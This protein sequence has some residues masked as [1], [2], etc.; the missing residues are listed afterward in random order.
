LRRTRE[1][2]VLWRSAAASRLLILANGTST[3][4]EAIE[5][6]ALRHL[7]G[8][9]CPPTDLESVGSKLRINAFEAADIPGSGEL[10]RDGDGFR[11]LYS[12]YLSVERRRFTIAHELAHALLEQTGSRAPRRGKELERLCD[13][14]AAELLMPKSVFL[15]MARG[16]VSTERIIDIARQFR[17]SV[18]ATGLRYAELRRVTVFAC[19]EL[20]VIWGK[21][22]YRPRT[23]GNVDESLRPA[24]L[25]ALDGEA[26]TDEV[27]L[28]SVASFQRWR[29]DCRPLARG[30][31]V[32]C[33]LQPAI[34][35]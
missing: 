34:R 17:T 18:T 4:E 31:R 3:V 29:I 12:T 30:R 28:D 19:E 5:Q 15:E 20:Q 10:R 13:M 33:L 9:K 2:K 22:S 25:K 24:I 6:L 23:R 7:D 1:P 35:N 11:I 21:G 27:F 8:V 16:E 32:L 14:F 26:S